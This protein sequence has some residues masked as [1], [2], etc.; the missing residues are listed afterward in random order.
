MLLDEN[1]GGEAINLGLEKA[2]GRLMHISE[3]DLE[4][5]AGWSEK[6]V[7]MF[8][9]FTSLGQLSLYGPVPDD[10]EVWALKPS[11][12]RHRKGRILYEA[13]N[14]VT[15]S[16]VFRRELWDKGLRVTNLQ[17]VNGVLFPN[18]QKLSNDIKAMG[19][20]VAWC[21]HYL[22]RNHGHSASEFEGRE[23]YYRK[24][25]RAKPW[26]GE[27]GWKERI[28]EFAQ[29]K[30]PVRASFLLD[31]EE[32]SAECS[33]PC[34]P[35]PQPRL[36]SMLDGKTPEIETLEFL[37]S[38]TRMAKPD[39]VLET[40]AWMGH[41]AVAI[42]RALAQNNIGRL[43]VLE[44]DPDCFEVASRRIQDKDLDG[45]VEVVSGSVLRYTPEAGIDFLLLDSY[46][47]RHVQEFRHLRPRLNPGC[48]IVVCDTGSRRGKTI[49]SF[50]QL[51][52]EFPLPGFFLP[53][54]RGVA[55]CRYTGALD[56]N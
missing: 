40:C 55:V 1:S 12:L 2:R 28:R 20:M 53:S 54:P 43:V 33:P 11:E 25:Y 22:V 52:K 39:Y 35:V 24:N 21:D 27:S 44:Q 45:V 9:T 49:Q 31:D 56:N 5:Q 6:V 36:W 10:E 16:C 17:E 23:E 14:N 26:V 34:K 15:T 29:Q 47:S 7:D 3:N 32:I 37:Y 51:T 13:L 4:Y 8:D 19:M 50:S 30:R 48:I 41:S 46:H 42:G 18:D 38:L